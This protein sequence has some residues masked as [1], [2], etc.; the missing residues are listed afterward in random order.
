[1]ARLPEGGEGIQKVLDEQPHTLSYFEV[2]FRGAGIDCDPGP[3]GSGNDP[4]T[5]FARCCRDDGVFGSKA[6]NLV[7]EMMAN[8]LGRGRHRGLA[9]LRDA[10]YA[11][12]SELWAF[13]HFTPSLLMSSDA[14]DDAQRALGL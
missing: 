2:L 3:E 1:M 11:N 14:P 5:E 9:H 8:A 13:H 4:Y 12:A 6:C 10:Y 7:F